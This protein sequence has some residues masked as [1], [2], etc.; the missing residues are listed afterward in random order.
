[1]KTCMW[2]VKQYT[3]ISGV[4]FRGL[5]IDLILTQGNPAVLSWE[6]LVRRCYLNQYLNWP[7]IF[8]RC[9]FLRCGFLVGLERLVSPLEV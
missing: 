5:N 6:F 7:E 8:K 4:V 9:E 2:T 3:N 1:M